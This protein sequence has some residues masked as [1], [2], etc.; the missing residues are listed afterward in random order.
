MDPTQ[1]QPFCLADKVFFDTPARLGDAGSRF[2]HADRAA[3]SG[4]ERT[5]K[6]LWVVLGRADVELPA[7]G[8]KIHVSATPDQAAHVVATVWDYCV[9]HGVAFKF[10]RSNGAANLVNGKDSN[11]GGSGKLVAIY[12]VDTEELTATLTGLA[13]SLAGVVGPY[14]LSDLRYGDGPL[15]VR[16]GA[17]TEAYTT[18]P[19][20]EPEPA[21]W[22]PDGTLVP[23]RR[24]PVFTV[25]D[26]VPV[27]EILHESLAARRA[28]AT[29]FPYDVKQALHFSNGGGVYLAVERATGVQVVLREARP[30]A[31]LDRD[32]VDAIAR[33]RREHVVLTSL[34]G[35]DCVPSVLG[36]HV[37]GEHHFLAEE[38]VEGPTL[39][40]ALLTRYPFVRPEPT[41]DDVAE[42][43]S[44]TTDVLAKVERALNAVHGR[45]V[46]FGDLHPNNILLRD[47]G[48]VV[49]IDFEVAGPIDDMTAPALQAPGFTPPSGVSGADVDRYALESLRLFLLLPLTQL[50]DRHPVK[51]LTLSG[52]ATGMFP[53]ASPQPGAGLVR[54]LR[55]RIGTAVDHAAVL[56]ARPYWPVIRD[57]L[58]SGMLASATPDRRDRLF[59]G[60]P[61]QFITNGVGLRTGAAGVLLALHG[62]G[63][64]IPDEYADWLV[65]TARRTAPSL[66]AGLYDGLHGVALVLD[67]MGRTEDSREILALARSTGDRVPVAG[68]LA[69][70]AGI[71]LTLLHFARQGDRTLFDDAAVLADDLAAFLTDETCRDGLRPPA[72]AGLLGGMTGVALLFLHLYQDSGDPRHLDLAELALRRD[73]EHCVLLDDGIVQVRDGSRHLGY[74][75]AG[76]GGIAVVAHEYLRHREDAEL[77]GTI[78]AIRRSFQAAYVFQP[79][80]LHGRAGVIAMLRHLDESGDDRY[81]VHDHV[82]RLGWHALTYRGEIA[83]PGALLQ[84][85]SMDL[86]TGSAGI[87]LALR[88]AFE[89]GSTPVLPF[90]DT[91]SPVAATSTTEGR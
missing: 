18:D 9:R 29:N 85:L 11:R 55:P 30:H 67:L 17:F 81:L 44:W 20:G 2:E 13:E 42:Y 70:R 12:P 19:E 7:Q 58:V 80:L 53:S 37:A 63:A 6:G 43:L 28:G 16:Y 60:G 47:D 33:L 79:G 24:D 39:L 26:W 49:L 76:S 50:V 54:Y 78:K 23:D 40:D 21:M 61:A 65:A 77:A 64:T 1:F 56:F 88:A 15:Y 3:P 75:D 84:R 5:E 74:L 59:P 27:P 57:S 45:G 91:R 41:D 66:R 87:L 14:I 51:A 71:A 89:D 34:A 83:F 46:R 68:M 86:A 72:K 82:R 36:Y 90:L 69:G 48:S 38:Y 8:W 73:L 25:P 62:V 31:A 35:L 4:W 10:L 32:G 52:V 22:A